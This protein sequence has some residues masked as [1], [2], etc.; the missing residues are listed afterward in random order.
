MCKFIRNT[1]NLD[2]HVRNYD[3][4]IPKKLE[5]YYIK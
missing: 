4:L 2:V 1:K 5:K 3:N